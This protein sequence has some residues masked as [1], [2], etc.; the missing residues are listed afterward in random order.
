[1]VTFVHAGPQLAE[2][3]IFTQYNSK[4]MDT[5]PAS[6]LSHYFVSERV[7]SL[8]DHEEIIKPTTSS[9]HAAQLLLS[10]VSSP[11]KVE[12]DT[13]PLT[14]ML[15]VMENHGDGATRALS[16]EMRENM[17]GESSEKCCQGRACYCMHHAH[18]FSLYF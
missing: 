9:Y 16:L 1:L 5:L 7:I 13:V 3:K 18:K 14:K 4:L 15:A 10:R 11:L 12:E 6:D 2:Y 17:F 8:A